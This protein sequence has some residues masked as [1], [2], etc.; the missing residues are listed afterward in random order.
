MVFQGRL[1]IGSVNFHRNYFGEAF[2]ISRDGREAFS[3]CVAF[4]LERW[5]YAFLERFGMNE[6]DWPDFDRLND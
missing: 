3:G 4:G 5:I 2:E 1:A 6:S